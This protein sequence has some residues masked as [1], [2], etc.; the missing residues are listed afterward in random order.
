MVNGKP[1]TDNGFLFI[2]TCT[3]KHMHCY[4][5]TLQFWRRLDMLPFGD[6]C[7]DT[8]IRRRWTWTVSS[9]DTK[10]TVWCTTMGRLGRTTYRKCCK[11]TKTKEC[12]WGPTDQKECNGED[13]IVCL[14][15]CRNT[16]RSKYSCIILACN[17]LKD[18]SP[19]DGSPFT[20]R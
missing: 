8:A 1:V 19:I 18:H 7:K 9:S 16:F 10:T 20:V 3:H 2:T 17:T 12:D 14:E 15:S 5:E 4:S 6:T 11:G 13:K